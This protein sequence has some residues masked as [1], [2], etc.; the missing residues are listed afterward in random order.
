MFDA[1]AHDLLTQPVIVRLTTLTPQGYPH[2]VPVWIMLD[3]DDL[4]MF[5]ER[6]AQKVKNARSNPKGAVAIGGDPIGS[7]CLLI[8]GDFTIEDDPDHAVTARITRHY[9]P[10]NVDQWLGM[11][12]NA[13][14]AVLRLK[15]HR[16]IRIS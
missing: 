15:P 6:S 9:D 10:Q 7:P 5:T 12:K 8:E 1:A 2:T 3:N 11:W 16:V 13:D 14:H 4:I